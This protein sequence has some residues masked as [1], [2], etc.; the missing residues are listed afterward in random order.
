MAV[1]FAGDQ[2]RASIGLLAAATHFFSRFVARHDEKEGRV[3][4]PVLHRG[5][6][7]ADADTLTR[8]GQQCYRASAGHPNVAGALR[9]KNQLMAALGL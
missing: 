8:C 3:L 4:W 2:V 9:F 1:G 7:P 6:G 5:E